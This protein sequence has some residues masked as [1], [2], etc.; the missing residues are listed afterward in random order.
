ML[1]WNLPAGPAGFRMRCFVAGEHA[2][3]ENVERGGATRKVSN[4]HPR[5]RS[6]GGR[7]TVSS[8]HHHHHPLLNAR[9]PYSIATTSSS[10]TQCTTPRHQRLPCPM[11][12]ATSSSSSS[13]T[14]T[15]GITLPHCTTHLCPPPYDHDSH[16]TYPMPPFTTMPCHHPPS[17]CTI[18][19]RPRLNVRCHVIIPSP[20]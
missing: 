19:C 7:G 10:P 14:A 15:T 6:R 2:L 16:R 11:Y 18:H 3:K 13:L 5:D 1:R 4:R 20:Q 17:K 9:P 8:P 12:D